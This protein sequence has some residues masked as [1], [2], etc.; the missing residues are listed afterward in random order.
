MPDAVR[1]AIPPGIS[2]FIAI[3]FVVMLLLTHK[4]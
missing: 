4:K 1:V 3:L 2:L